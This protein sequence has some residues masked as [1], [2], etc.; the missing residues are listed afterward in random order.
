MELECT[1]LFAASRVEL[2][3]VKL[4]PVIYTTRKSEHLVRTEPN[5]PMGSHERTEANA[6]ENQAAS[7]TGSE[8]RNDGQTVIG[9]NDLHFDLVHEFFK[10]FY[11]LQ[12]F[13]YR[14]VASGF[15]TLLLDQGSRLTALS[16]RSPTSFLDE[17]R[18]PDP[19]STA[20]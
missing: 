1:T 6:T 17:L 10:H 8:A 11:T 3:Y 7:A 9:R 5:Q 12:R 16:L 20:A 14:R 4:H 15:N 19:P 13:K 2:S 18:P